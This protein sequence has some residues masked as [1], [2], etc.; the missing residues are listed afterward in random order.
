[1]RRASCAARNRARRKATG[2]AALSAVWLAARSGPASVAQWEPSRACSGFRIVA[3]GVAIV[4]AAIMTATTIFT[5]ID[6][7]MRHCGMVRST[8]PQMCD[9]TSGNSEIPRSRFQRAPECSILQPIAGLEDP[10]HG[11]H[12]Y[13]QEH[14]RDAD[15][16]ADAAV[17]DFIK[18]AA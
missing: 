8:R 13:G 10:P 4:A 1:M 2:L 11:N 17:G 18:T 15:A 6:N 7:F 3:G 12:A 5:A 9:C 14:Q 16:D